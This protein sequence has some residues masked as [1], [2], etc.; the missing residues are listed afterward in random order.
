MKQNKQ[1][2]QLFDQKEKLTEM[3]LAAEEFGDEEKSADLHTKN[4]R[5]FV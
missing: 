5:I 1:L 2:S 3:L 4:G